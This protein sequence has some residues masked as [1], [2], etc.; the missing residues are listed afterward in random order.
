MIGRVVIPERLEGQS[1]GYQGEND[2]SCQNR[3][4]GAM[5]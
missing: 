1:S 2:A 3:A 5:R 4:H